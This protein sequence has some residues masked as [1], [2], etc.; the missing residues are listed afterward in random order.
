MKEFYTI[1]K[2]E[3]AEIVEKK[4]KFIADIYPVKNVEE[5]ENKIKEIKKKYYDAKHHCIAYR[6][7]EEDRI[8]EKSSDDGEP[9]GTAG[10]PMLNILQGSNLCNIIVIVTR[11]FGGILLGT[12]GL[13]RA[14]SDATK[15]AIQKSE[16][17]FQKDGFEIELE[18]DYSNLENFKY[19]CKSNDIN[20][21][22]IDY[23]ENIRIK[24]EMEKEKKDIFLPEVLYSIGE[25]FRMK[26]EIIA[27]EES[28]GRISKEF[29]YLYPPGIPVIVPGEKISRE[30]LEYLQ[31]VRE[32]GLS[33]QGLQDYEQK[34]ICCIR[35]E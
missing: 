31:E 2:N 33:V 28:A 34:K 16:L 25:A 20:I 29:I 27:L 30:L 24:I 22:N 8:I 11:Y 17:L 14:Y 15:K 12:G 13:V 35:N 6:I 23:S 1:S 26:E 5:A 3:T 21:I 32:L 4:S 10:A 9:S 18:T 7:V 19:Y